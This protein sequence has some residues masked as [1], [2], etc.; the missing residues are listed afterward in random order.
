MTSSFS[1]QPQQST[2]KCKTAGRAEDHKRLFYGFTHFTKL[3]FGVKLTCRLVPECLQAICVSSNM[4]V[5][6]RGA[7]A[8]R[9]YE[10]QLFHLAHCPYH[11]IKA[12]NLANKTSLTSV[13]QDS[14]AH[15][16]IW[17]T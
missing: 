17:R 14:P 7:L 6:C 15:I 5:K 9:Q 16:S 2:A 10:Q 1:L 11:D 4:V 3:N 8:L 12:V 13:S